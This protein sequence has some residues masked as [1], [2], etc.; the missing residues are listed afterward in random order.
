[1]STKTSAFFKKNFVFKKRHIRSAWKIHPQ[2]LMANFF[3]SCRGRHPLRLLLLLQL[4]GADLHPCDPAPR[5]RGPRSQPAGR[6]AGETAK[7]HAEV[8]GAAEG[9]LER[10][11]WSLKKDRPKDGAKII[12][13]FAFCIMQNGGMENAASKIIDSLGGTVAA[14][15]FFGVA[16]STISC[17]RRRGIPAGR[18]LMLLRKAPELFW[19]IQQDEESG[20]GR[21]VR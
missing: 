9:I 19:A 15:R 16:P 1:M 2:K 3:D 14:S 17:W 8:C 12:L 13:A 4:A 11:A 10:L 7:L 20:D 5:L 6:Y 18:R 21:A